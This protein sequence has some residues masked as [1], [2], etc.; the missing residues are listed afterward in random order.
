MWYNLKKNLLQSSTLGKLLMVLLL[1]L[2]VTLKGED[3]FQEASFPGEG[4]GYRGGT[5]HPTI[6]FDPPPI[7]TDAPH[8]VSPW[9]N[10][11]LKMKPPI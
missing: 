2:S 8:R 11:H 9:G 1:G 4:L 7:K 5:P 6:F 10:P 3:Q